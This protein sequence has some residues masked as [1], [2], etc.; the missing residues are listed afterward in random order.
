MKEAIN[1]LGV[2]IDRLLTFQEETNHLLKKMAAG[3]KTI[4][5]TRRTIPDNMEKT[6][7]QRII[8]ESHSLFSNYHSV[9]QTKSYS[10]T[11][12]TT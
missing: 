2:H 5:K 8:V 9:Y 4:H 6:H 11:W 7:S 12:R 3:I 10:N 1:Y